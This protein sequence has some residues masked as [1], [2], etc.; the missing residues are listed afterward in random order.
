MN[1]RRLLKLRGEQ[2]AMLRQADLPKKKLEALAK[3]L[4]RKRR[5][6]QT[7]EGMWDSEPFPHL[8]PLS[9]PKS[10][11]VKR[12]TAKSIL[13]QL[14]EDLDCWDEALPE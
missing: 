14:E 2:Q 8:M 1:R 6:Q 11:P 3:K 13:N 10:T 5:P 7:G 4:G 12:F 9:I